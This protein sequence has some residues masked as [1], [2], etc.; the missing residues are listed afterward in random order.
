MRGGDGGYDHPGHHRRQYRLQRHQTYPQRTPSPHRNGMYHHDHRGRGHGDDY[1]MPPPMHPMRRG[2]PPH[3]M[4][5]HGRSHRG[6]YRGAH[7]HVLGG[8]SQSL[9]AMDRRKTPLPPPNMRPPARAYH[10][11]G[12]MQNMNNGNIPR[13]GIQSMSASLNGIQQMNSN[14][15]NHLEGHKQQQLGIQS[16]SASLNGMQQSMN[17]APMNR[18]MNGMN[19]M[20]ASQNGMS[21][22]NN[23]NRSMNGSINGF[24]VTSTPLLEQVSNLASLANTPNQMG[25]HDMLSKSLMEA[26]KRTASSR[27]L[28]KD[29]N[30]TAMLQGDLKSPTSM[31]TKS[32]VKAKRNAGRLS[33]TKSKSEAT[34]SR[35]FLKSKN[36]VEVVAV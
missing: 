20:S 10:D 29:L 8:M 4:P 25:G 17:G 34:A 6:G 27:K 33:Y 11:H 28:I 1:E 23:M 35:E 24:K 30:I 32:V 7:G 12:G 15:K 5:H 3:D 18:S 21:N 31:K 2:P 26:M 14:Y 13:L 16:M 9:N 36:Q 22:M 19:S